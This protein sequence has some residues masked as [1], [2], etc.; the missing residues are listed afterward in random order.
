MLIRLSNRPLTSAD[1]L[2]NRVISGAEVQMVDQ[3][4]VIL[5]LRYYLPFNGILYRTG[6]DPI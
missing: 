6:S 2:W 5:T 1:S 4:A 3:C